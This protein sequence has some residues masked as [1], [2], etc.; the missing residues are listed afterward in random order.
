MHMLPYYWDNSVMATVTTSTGVIRI[1][2]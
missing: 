2:V 1:P